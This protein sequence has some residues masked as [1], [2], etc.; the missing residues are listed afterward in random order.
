[1]TVDK[2]ITQ[3]PFQGGTTVA[4]PILRQTYNSSTNFTVPA[5]VNAIWVHLVG[6][7]AGGGGKMNTGFNASGTGGAGGNGTFGYTP[8]T[9]GST[10][11]IV[12]GA[13]GTFGTPSAGLNT[14]Q[15]NDG[16]ETYVNTSGT[17][18]GAGGGVG[19]AFPQTGNGNYGDSF[20]GRI[21]GITRQQIVFGAKNASARQFVVAGL[22][23]GMAFG[24]LPQK[25]SYNA[26]PT[27][28][29]SN[30]S[31]GG[32]AGGSGTPNSG[33]PAVGGTGGNQTT[34][35]FTGG[36][37]V[38]GAILNAGGGG[39][40]AG[41]TGNGTAGSGATGGQGGAGGG[42]GGGG[43]AFQ[44]NNNTNARGGNGGAGAVR[45]YY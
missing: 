11:G 6:G 29:G 43:G 3:A 37:G 16:G 22:A 18:F 39:G 27:P 7:G 28:N 44:A 36:A 23:E 34:Y 12:I 42:G 4:T 17:C 25:N 5:T 13:G 45:I 9:P 31:Y 15:A 40:G 19:Q 35:G 14:S 8:V 30:A 26:G 1:M 33:S 38:T 2:T 10:V 20:T 41:M 32:A 24:G 21:I